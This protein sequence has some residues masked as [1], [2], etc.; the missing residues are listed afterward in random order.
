MADVQESVKPKPKVIDK[1]MQD[2]LA[3]SII[4]TV[5]RVEDAYSRLNVAGALLGDGHTAADVSADP[6]KE[7][8]LI[9]SEHFAPILF[10]ANKIGGRFQ[11]NVCTP[12]LLN[13]SFPRPISFTAFLQ[14]VEG[15]S[16]PHI[17]VKNQETLN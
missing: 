7:F 2:K 1:V 17:N 12:F 13:N 15:S 9:L 10:S 14:R 6:F 8:D 16:L 11:E 5:E 4:E 3:V